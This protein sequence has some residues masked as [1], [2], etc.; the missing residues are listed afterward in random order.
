MLDR[1]DVRRDAGTGALRAR[2]GQEKS[3]QD[4]QRER[5][6]RES[7]H[8]RF[9]PCASASWRRAGHWASESAEFDGGQAVGTNDGT[10]KV[11]ADS[12]GGDEKSSTSAI[13]LAAPSRGVRGGRFHRH[14]I[15]L[16]T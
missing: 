9:Q 5:D 8:V 1:W 10:V 4:R 14:S 16:S 12:S 13:F 2:A 3:G 11:G 7:P 6:Q 15:A